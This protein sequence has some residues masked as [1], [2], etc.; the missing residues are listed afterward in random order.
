M[1]IK[2]RP[3]PGP[4]I[5]FIS[6]ADIAWQIII[7]FLI[8]STFTHHDS[9]NVAMPSAGPL[10][11]AAMNKTITIEV[12]ENALAVN[13]VPVPVGE[14]ESYL[15]GLLTGLKE[16]Q[17]RA[18]VVKPADDLSFQRNADVLFAIQKA[19]GIAVISEERQSEDISETN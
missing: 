17:E 12:A 15:T 7:F 5:P 16:E 6:L 1:K 2:R 10:A 3:T 18:V 8:A 14:L 4:W 13:G 9:L 19:G 11:A